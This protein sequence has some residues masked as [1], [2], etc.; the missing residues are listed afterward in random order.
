MT[1][2]AGFPAAISFAKFGPEIAQIGDE[3]S[4][5]ARTCDIRSNEPRSNPF[6][7]LAT[8]APAQ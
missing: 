1:V 5:S 3:G 4:S 2:A 7:A 6:A 8:T